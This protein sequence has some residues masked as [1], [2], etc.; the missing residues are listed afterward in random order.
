MSLQSHE[1]QTRLAT[2]RAEVFNARYRVGDAVM[3]IA[4]FLVELYRQRERIE[5]GLPP[6]DRAGPH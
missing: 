3:Y 5:R 6:T 1:L 2:R 4:A